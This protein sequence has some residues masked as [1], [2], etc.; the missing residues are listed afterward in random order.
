MTP[1]RST[2]FSR[3]VRRPAT[4][5]AAAVLAGSLLTAHA[6]GAEAQSRPAL[7]GDRDAALQDGRPLP[8][9]LY[10]TPEFSRAVERGTRTRTG[11]PGPNYWIQHARYAIAVRLDPDSGRVRGRERV[12]YLNRSPDTLRRVAVYLRQNVFAPGSPRRNAAPLTGGMRIERVDVAGREIAR[13]GPRNPAVPITGTPQG[14]PATG[15]YGV[16]GT[17]MWIALPSPLP[18]GD[19]VS[20][21]LAWSYPPAPAP[22]DG[23]EGREGDVWFMGFWYPQLAVYDDVEGWVTDPYLNGAEFYMGS[24]DYDVRITVPRGWVVGATGTLRN[25][26]EVLS[27]RTRTR[28][29]E[30][31]RTGHVVHVV[32]ADERGS[33]AVFAAGS[34]EVTWH[35]TALDVRDFAW[36]TSRDYLWDATR[37]LV[38]GSV[39]AAGAGRRSTPPDTILIQSFYRPTDAAAAWEVGG[40]RF[41]RYAIERLSD[42]L[43]PYPWPTMTSMEGI[44]RSGG[45][46]YPMMTLMQPWADTLSLAGDLMHETGH[47]WFPMQVGSNETRHPW[48]DEGLTQFDVAQ[49][50][51]ALYGEPR[52]GGRPNDSEPGQRRL[53]LEAA[54]TGHEASLMRHGDRFP[55]ELYLVMYYD[56]TAQVLAALRSLLGEATFHEALREYGRRWTGKH[57]YPVD[58]FNTFGDVSGRDLSWFWR[59]WFY[60]P[61]YLD[62]ALGEVRTEGDSVSISVQDRGLAPMPVRLAVTRAGGSVQRL[63]LPAGVWLG[64]SRRHRVRVAAR[65]EVL[66][67]EIDPEEAFPDID[68]SNQVWE[69]SGGGRQ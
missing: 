24:A 69:R 1:N 32:T 63:E 21:A 26:R 57:P 53:Y 65:P 12:W 66:K 52:E 22:A 15:R 64:G 48:M 61:W 13:E 68:R 58:F 7:A 23:R 16:D 49:G 9:P 41:T 10:E 19:S 55:P 39:N 36:G 60:Q 27:E 8:G 2:R 33:G 50:M 3:P 59:T 6:G 11:R 18:P 45:M 20:L 42:Y 46:E 40:A 28:I 38:G 34:P 51:R 37:A 5:L 35:F 30:A 14:P 17:V 31:R 67:V 43:W 44:L 4:R 62:Q 25:D 47:M 29:E 56:K 54:R